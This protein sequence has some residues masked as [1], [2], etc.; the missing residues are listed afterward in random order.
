VEAAMLTPLIFTL[1]FG[2]LEFGWSIHSKLSISNM[3]LSGARTATTQGNDPLT[4]YNVLKAV[5]RASGG[6]PRS[7][8]Q[9]IVVYRASGPTD[10][11]PSTCAAG[12]S[13]SGTGVGACNVY[14]A[15][16]MNL[17]MS[18]FGGTGTAV[19]RYWAPTGRHVKATDPPDYVGVY[20]KVFHSNITKL[21]GSGYTFTDDTILR[22]E[23]QQF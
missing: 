2:M 11:V 8:I 20:I 18:S 15:S 9:Y 16:S 1:L 19:D 22:V 23:A 12:T 21:F 13:V 6:M 3:A 4:D 10:K 7:E 17:P 14:T 5:A